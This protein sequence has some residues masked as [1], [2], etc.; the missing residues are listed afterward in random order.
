MR[1]IL[2]SLESIQSPLDTPRGPILAN[3]QGLVTRD[4]H[5]QGQVSLNPDPYFVSQYTNFV[6]MT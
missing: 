3:R 5:V 6:S 4:H 2:P 1:P